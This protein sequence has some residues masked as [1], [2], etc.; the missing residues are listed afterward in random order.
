MQQLEK[1]REQAKNAITP[2]PDTVPAPLIPDG[3]EVTPESDTVPQLLIPDGMEVKTMRVI[4]E[5]AKEGET[6]IVAHVFAQKKPKDTQAVDHDA[7]L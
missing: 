1:I 4:V 2:K 6:D 5:L 7:S 3:M